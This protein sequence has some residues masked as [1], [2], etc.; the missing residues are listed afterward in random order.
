MERSVQQNTKPETVSSPGL[1]N[2]GAA[3]TRELPSWMK[4]APS[5]HDIKEESTTASSPNV[6]KDKIKK[7]PKLL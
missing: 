3:K 2:T 4:R 1:S 6:D 7:K 5:N